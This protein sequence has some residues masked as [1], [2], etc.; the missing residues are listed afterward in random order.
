MAEKITT[1]PYDPN[2]TKELLQVS[3]L[4][5]SQPNGEFVF[6]LAQQ[7]KD[8]HDTLG[9]AGTDIFKAQEAVR[10]A[11]RQLFTETQLH[12]QTK[13]Q[14]DAKIIKM[15]LSLKVY[16]DALSAIA[17]DAR[18]AKKIATAALTELSTEH[19]IP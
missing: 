10:E 1:M 3:F 5:R 18:G 4:H 16:G 11:D 7:L 12:K 2:K 14:F 6:N 19:P 13:N 17:K 9:S 15:K 8:A